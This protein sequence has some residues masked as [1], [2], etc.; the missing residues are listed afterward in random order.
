M[1]ERR[2]T[3]ERGP[4]HEPVDEEGVRP[5]SDRYEDA[6]R[7]LAR[8]IAQ[9]ELRPR[10]TA[11]DGLDAAPAAFVALLAGETVGTTIVRVG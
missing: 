9:G 11:F 8:W 6:R 4:I 1:Q 5:V 2:P 10:V 7:D 3:V